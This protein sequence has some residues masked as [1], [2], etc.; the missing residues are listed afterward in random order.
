MCVSP[1]NKK[2]QAFFSFNISDLGLVF[3]NAFFIDVETH[4]SNPYSICWWASSNTGSP[5]VA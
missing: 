1:G 3:Y 2:A 4:L 5:D